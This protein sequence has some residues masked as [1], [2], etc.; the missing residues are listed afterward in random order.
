VP[1][2]LFCGSEE[3]GPEESLRPW[4]PCQ[5]YLSYA[6]EQGFLTRVHFCSVGKGKTRI[7]TVERGNGR[8]GSTKPLYAGRKQLGFG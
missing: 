4:K 5:I 6:T 1:A 7:R 8:L 3:S 2:L